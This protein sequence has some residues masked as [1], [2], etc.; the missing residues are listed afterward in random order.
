MI[1]E[2]LFGLTMIF[3]GYVMFEVYKVVKSSDDGQL[4]HVQ[5]APAPKQEEKP[6]AKPA[7]AR[8]AKPKAELKAAAAAKPAPAPAPVAA[9]AAPAAEEKTIT[10]KD[11]ASGDTTA[12]PSNYRFAKKWVKEALVKEGL[13][14]KVYK[15]SELKGD[16]NGQVKAALDKFKDIKKYH[17]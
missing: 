16:L 4:T 3:V 17:A 12:V 8:A 15:N 1:E 11:P 14:P 13:L 10:L 7:P 2:I 5:P 6:A 9:A